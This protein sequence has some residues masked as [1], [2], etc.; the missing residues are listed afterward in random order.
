MQLSIACSLAAQ[1]VSLLNAR[2]LLVGMIRM[3][4]PLNGGFMRKTE[5]AGLDQVF[6]FATIILMT[7]I[8]TCPRRVGFSIV[9]VCFRPGPFLIIR[10]EGSVFAPVKYN[11]SDS[12]SL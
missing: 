6:F 3:V 5:H 9:F 12:S 4:Y 2:K 8:F 11:L 10:G 1:A 7:A